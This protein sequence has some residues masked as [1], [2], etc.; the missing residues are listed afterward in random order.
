MDITL[1][2]FEEDDAHYE[3]LAQID[4]EVYPDHPVT[5][6]SL[7]YDD[8]SFDRS[9]CLLKRHMAWVQDGTPAGYVAYHHM[10]SRYHPQRLWLWAAVRPAFQGRGIGT[11]LYEHAMAQLSE[12]GARW[13][14]TSTREMMPDTLRYLRTRGFVEV[15]RSWESHLDVQ[16]FDPTPFAAYAPRMEQEGIRFTTVAEERGTRGDWLERIFELHTTL[17]ADVPSTT[18]YTV[19]SMDTFVRHAVENPE[20][21]LDGY[22]IAV[23]G[24]RYVGESALFAS[25][26]QPGSLYQG[27]T[28][29]RRDYRGRGIAMALKLQTI[30]YAKLHGYRLI[31]TWNA[32]VNEGMLAINDRLGFVRQ[33]A[34][35]EFEKTLSAG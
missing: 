7:R 8:R 20:A 22:F 27:L 6:A 2:D 21:L 19:P 15:L 35:V 29:V 30:D 9:K 33:P 5:A 11:A 1:R 18:P 23:Q 16:G 34:W 24:D 10:E 28:A 25:Q 3:A 14:H 4:T 12:L 26:A 31:K 32:T 13:L 17:M